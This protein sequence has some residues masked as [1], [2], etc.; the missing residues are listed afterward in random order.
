M[1]K[2]RVVKAH[3]VEVKPFLLADFTPKKEIA[4]TIKKVTKKESSGKKQCCVPKKSFIEI[5]ATF[6]HLVSM[7]LITVTWFML[8]CVM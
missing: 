7:T 1:K 2:V 4:D 8:T 3:E 5:F 6:F